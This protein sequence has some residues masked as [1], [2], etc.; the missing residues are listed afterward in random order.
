LIEIRFRHF[1]YIANLLSLLRLILVIPI[2]MLLPRQDSASNLI[3]LGLIGIAIASD[4]LD[5]FFARKLN[6]QTDLGRILDPLADKIL[7]VLG[8]L[9]FVIFRGFPLALVILLAYRD[10]VILI[11]GII[12]TKKTGRLTESNIFGKGNTL[13]ISLAGFIFL[14]SPDWWGTSALFYLSYISIIISGCSYLLFAFR[15]LRI[16]ISV[17][18][19]MFILAALP[20]ILVLYFMHDRLA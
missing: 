3:L 10:L 11:G 15:S 12:I 8:L 19:M 1:F 18:T 16:N 14:I 13:I 5:G 7:I 4:W 20:V 2:Y 17:R 6:Q 9:G